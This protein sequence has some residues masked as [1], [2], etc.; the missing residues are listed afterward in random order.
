MIKAIICDADGML[1]NGDMFSLHLAQKYGISKDKMDTFFTGEF[2]DCLVGK[3]DLRDVISKYLA[4]WGLRK[5]VDDLL[6]EWFE[7]EHHIDEDLVK[8]LNILRHKGIKVYLATNQEKHRTQYM[9]DKMEF[10]KFFDGI[11][12]SAYLGHKKPNRE[13]F[14]RVLDKMKGIQVN[15]VLFWDD[16]QKNID[17]A[18]AFGFNAELYVGF[19]KF[20]TSIERYLQ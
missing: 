10:E 17:G 16:Q 6:R 19:S 15:E 2:Q 12:S 18:K 11:F 7:F 20:K 13:F 4:S 3:C 1:I 5:S 14:E 8:Y 9:L